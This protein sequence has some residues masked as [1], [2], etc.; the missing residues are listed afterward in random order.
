MALA[1]ALAGLDGLRS[2]RLITTSWPDREIAPG[3]EICTAWQSKMS[4][5]SSGLRYD[6]G[7]LERKLGQIH[8]R[9]RL[10]AAP[11]EKHLPLER[12]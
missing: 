10:I 2:R 12:A 8:H 6:G 3:R 1:S 5:G 4:A 9:G 11:L 7:A